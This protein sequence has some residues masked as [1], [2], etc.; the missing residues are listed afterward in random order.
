MITRHH[1][2]L[3]TC[4]LTVTHSLQDAGPWRVRHGDQA[5]K[6]KVTGWHEHDVVS[7]RRRFVRVDNRRTIWHRQP[8]VRKCDHSSTNTAVS[9]VRGHERVTKGVVDGWKRAIRRT[10]GRTSVEYDFRRTL[11]QDKALAAC[12][13][14]MLFLRRLL[15]LLRL[16][17]L[18]LLAPVTACVR[19]RTGGTYSYGRRVHLVNQVNDDRVRLRTR[20]EGHFRADRGSLSH[21]Q[22]MLHAKGEKESNVDGVTR[23]LV[24]VCRFDACRV[25]QRADDGRI[26]VGRRLRVARV[27]HTVCRRHMANRTKPHAGD[28]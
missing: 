23:H 2:H 21:L 10:G 19:L 24:A 16:R 18:G 28:G 8:T 12:A 7:C 17:L 13:A 3:D 6:D 26:S 15:L 20:V 22:A 1:H 25:A 5:D 14:D 27:P 9:S 4:R 11:Q